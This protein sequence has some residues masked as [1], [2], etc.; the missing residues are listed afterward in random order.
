M[1]KW[2]WKAY[3]NMLV[4]FFFW[5]VAAHTH[6]HKFNG[7]CADKNI[8]NGGLYY[9]CNTFYKYSKRNL[10]K[11]IFFLLP[12]WNSFHYIYE[13]TSSS[14][15]QCYFTWFS[16]RSYNILR[17]NTGSIF[18]VLLFLIKRGIQS[19]VAFCPIK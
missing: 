14:P 5:S 9:Y 19:T 4:G 15:F 1:S 18:K 13:L 17:Y 12:Q 2:C 11:K 8:V 10:K 7:N 16:L 3:K 6:T